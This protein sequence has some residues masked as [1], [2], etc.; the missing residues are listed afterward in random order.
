MRMAE[1]V[2]DTRFVLHDIDEEAH[3]QALMYHNEWLAI[4]YVLI[5][6]PSG[7]TLRVMKNLR[8]CDNCHV[9]VKLI[10]EIE[11]RE[12]IAR[13]NYKRFHSTYKVHISNIQSTSV[14]HVNFV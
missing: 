5:N 6:T 3:A 4:A 2:P 13:N 7:T 9:V 12:I 1:Y 14:I 8:I 11:G 10:S